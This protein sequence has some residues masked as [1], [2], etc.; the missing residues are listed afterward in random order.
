MKRQVALLGLAIAFAVAASA[1]HG[2]VQA[3][4]AV[5]SDE[6]AAHPVVVFTETNPWLM[7]I[8]SDVPSFALYADGTVIYRKGESYFTA[9]L[10]KNE[11]ARI[12]ASARLADEV[13]DIAI[14]DSTDQ[15]TTTVLL[16]ENGKVS[17]VR[18]YGRVVGG[19][20]QGKLTQRM[21][22]TV[23]TLRKFD[24]VDARPWLPKNIEVMIWPYEYAPEA[25]IGWPRDWPG[26]KDS[27]TVQRGDSYSLYLPS[28]HFEELKALLARQ[29]PRGAVKIDGHKWA[30]AWRLPF[31][32]VR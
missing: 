22:E 28:G 16:S 25:S 9:V 24:A 1:S 23:Q 17:G 14:S 12:V 7:V 13:V 21:I 31:P 19:E 2:A 3:P 32:G 20:S 18:I 6:L 4:A 15:P 26:L 5:S 30:V 29:K 10:P 27:A 8:G 11:V